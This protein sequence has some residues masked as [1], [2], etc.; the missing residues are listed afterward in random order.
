M[1]VNDG[2]FHVCKVENHWNDV[3]RL[4][5]LAGLGMTQPTQCNLWHPK[6]ANVILELVD[7]LEQKLPLKCFDED[8]IRNKY[9]VCHEECINAVLQQETTRFSLLLQT[10]HT[11]LVDIR[12]A[13][14]GQI[15]LTPE[16]EEMLDSF[17][18]G[19][20]P[21]KWA[22]ASYPSLKPLGGYVND[23]VAR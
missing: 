6:T 18:A 14:K 11:S 16:L 3:V 7:E 12:K 22:K 13:I 2:Q 8:A 1:L 21:K 17:S 9:P 20:V 10:I 15:I 5:L 23:L 19:H 4:Q